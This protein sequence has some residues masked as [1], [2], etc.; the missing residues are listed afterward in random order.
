MSTRAEIAAW[1]V[2]ASH[3]L[4]DRGWVA[5]HDGNVS[6]KLD[7][8]RYL[9]TPTAISKIDV[10][11]GNL[12]VVGGD[13]KPVE[14]ET[15]PPSEFALHLGAYAERPDIGAVVHAHP[16]FATALACAGRSLTSFL[17][18]AVVSIGPKV[19][20]AEFALPYG[21]AG[22]AP[23]RRL[24]GRN[25]ALLLC[26]HGVI[27]V[28]KDLEQALLRMELVEHMA[29]IWTLAQPLGG[30]REL[31]IESL[32]ILVGKRR[33]AK[34]GLA[35]DRTELPG[36]GEESLVTSTPRV[37]AGPAPAP[38]AWSGGEAAA[39]CGHVYGAVEQPSGRNAELE[40]VVRA[41][42]TDHLKRS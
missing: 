14:G 16:P 32:R 10:R 8:G 39:T 4:F 21:A 38:D 22:A 33:G 1:I 29:R 30:V 2:R 3:L 20:L 37:T 25:D 27:T 15:R 24:I 5:N 13:G 18:E 35:A 19:P 17:P 26:N 41:A 12:A 23:I 9:V 7:G 42:I 11:E 6:V 34:L 31:D 40:S 28:G 36:E